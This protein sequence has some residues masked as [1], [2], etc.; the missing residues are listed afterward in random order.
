DES[1][2]QPSQSSLGSAAGG[3]FSYLR[4]HPSAEDT[5]EGIVE[6]WLLE[7]RIRHTV[8]EVKN[9]LEELV[10][11][12]LVSVQQHQDGRTCYKAHLMV[13]GTAESQAASSEND[14]S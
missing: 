9:A 8:I 3:I 6:W 10:A 12:G 7:T 13:D 2:K 4:D 5:L 1:S 14:T 11:L